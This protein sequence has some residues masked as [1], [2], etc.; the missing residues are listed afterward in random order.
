M[1]EMVEAGDMRA[2]E[3]ILLHPH[4]L[5]LGSHIFNQKTSKHTTKRALHRT[6]SSCQGCVR[7]E[8]EGELQP[9]EVL[10]K[11]GG[12]LEDPG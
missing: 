3:I 2:T 11:V 9:L 4:V 6:R 8:I 7:F 12:Q 1:A 10:D 5:P